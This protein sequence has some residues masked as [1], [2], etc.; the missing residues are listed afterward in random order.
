MRVV[1]ETEST[2]N[3]FVRCRR[4]CPLTRGVQLKS[5]DCDPHVRLPFNPGKANGTRR[6]VPIDVRVIT[7]GGWYIH[8]T[9]DVSR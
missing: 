9:E 2:Y 3:A 7:M 1:K 6:A 4:C 5:S 8:I